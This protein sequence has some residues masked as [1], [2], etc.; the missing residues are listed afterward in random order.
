MIRFGIGGKTVANESGRLGTS[1]DGRG[2]FKRN[3][4]NSKSTG[5]VEKAFK[6]PLLGDE[7]LGLVE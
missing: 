3:A 7:T 1:S 4:G 5:E 2:A 6:V